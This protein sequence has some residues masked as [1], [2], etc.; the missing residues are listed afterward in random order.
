M[1]YGH[2]KAF[3]LPVKHTFFM[4]ELNW[5][6]ERCDGKLWKDKAVIEEVWQF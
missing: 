6:E 2:E 3:K 1:E 5:S 4:Y